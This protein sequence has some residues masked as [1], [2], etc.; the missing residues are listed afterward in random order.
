MPVVAKIMAG[1]DYWEGISLIV[2][3]SLG[4][5]FVFLY[6]LPV[7]IEYY[8]KKTGFISL[9]TIL[10]AVLNVLL[11]YFAINLFGYRAAAYT[12]LFS[13]GLLFLFHW[14]IAKKYGVSD[15]YD[16]N[17][18]ISRTAI[19]LVVGISILFFKTGG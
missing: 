15:I 16:T 19:V 11:N 9:G 8:Y 13:Y 5:Y 10:A 14:K 7:N 17:N 2:P 1:R 3:L 6:G 4:N 12:T 18:L